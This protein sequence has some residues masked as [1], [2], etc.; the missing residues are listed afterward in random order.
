[1]GNYSDAVSAAIANGTLPDITAV[2]HQSDKYGVSTNFEQTLSSDIGLF[3][4]ASMN[5]GDKETWD[6]TDI[7]RSVSLGLSIKGTRWSRAQDTIGIAGV[8]NGIS[9]SA[10]QYFNDGGLGVLI[11]DGPHSGY[12]NE[13]ILETFYNFGVNKYVNVTADYQYIENPAY[14][15]NMGPISVL[16]FR[17]HLE[18]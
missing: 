2:R 4:R 14:N 11:G 5:E 12:G 1:M 8:I 16:G 13:K 3:G 15:P 18:N 7:S 17:L 6:F 10:S 9:S